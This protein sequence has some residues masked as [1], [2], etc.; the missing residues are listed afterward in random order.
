VQVQILPH[1]TC[2]WRKENMKTRIIV[3]ILILL[4]CTGCVDHGKS[5]IDEV[6]Y[7]GS[8]NEEQKDFILRVEYVED[9]ITFSP[10]F[11]VHLIG[12]GEQYPKNME[13]VTL[14][15]YGAVENQ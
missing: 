6:K 2:Y 15:R 9:G 13:V 1:F 11:I 14:N 5:I 8:W 12:R 10:S 7:R 4:S 3:V